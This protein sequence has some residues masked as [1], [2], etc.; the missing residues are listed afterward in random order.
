MEKL[1]PMSHVTARVCSLPR[2]NRTLAGPSVRSEEGREGEGIWV[3][4]PAKPLLH[5]FSSIPPLPSVFA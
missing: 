5:H 3:P 2:Y 1:F 4:P